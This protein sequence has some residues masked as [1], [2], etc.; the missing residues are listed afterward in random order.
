MKKIIYSALVLAAATG[1]KK[2]FFNRAPEDQATVGT[3]YQTTDEVQSS[4]N[5]LYAAPWFGFNGKAFLAVG[6]LQAGN[7][8]CYAGTDGE[9]DA[10]RNFSQG[11]ATL[12]V[13]STWNSLYTV[14]AQAN[15]LLN[16]LPSAVPGSVPASV[17][18][19][20]L[21][22]ARTM[23]AAAY[24]Y[25]VR[26][27]GNVPIITDPAKYTGTFQTVPTNPVTDIYKFITLDLQ[28]AEANCTHGDATSG[29]VSS[30][31]ASGLLAKVYLYEQKYDS[32]QI[33]A[34]KVINSGYF[35]L[36][37]L[38]VAGSYTGIFEL[39]GNNC[40][41]SMI[42]LQWTSNGGY[43]FG[44]QIQSVI[45]DGENGNFLTGTGDG[46]GELGPSWDLQDAFK[47]E[48][49]SIRRHGCI[50]LP[51]EYY[52]E[53]HKAQGG[54]TCPLQVNE[55][56]VHAAMKKYVVGTPA[57]N[58]G[59]SAA[60]ATSNNTYILRYA[61]IYLIE[62]EA[63]MGKAAGVTPGTGM[64]LSTTSSDPTAL[65]YIN[66]IRQRAG[67]GGWTSFS[68]QQLL[69]ERRL[70]FAIEAD[71]WYD[72]Q[73]IDGFNNAHHP[74]AISIISQQNRGDSNSAG[75]A[76]NNYTDYQR[77]TVYVTP[78]DANFLMPIPATETA[79]DP[80]LL[81]PPVPYVF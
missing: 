49:D 75:T 48:G 31:S 56:G 76:A 80:T 67:L 10:F 53:L 77:N 1:C 81:Q 78:T 30:E 65:K 39:A 72:L 79:A 29:H 18:N 14:V 51:G 22:E 52:A 15:A 13:Q 38:D 4:P 63:I 43:G 12:A 3:Y 11:N 70:E 44:N 27:F 61:D 28:F 62:A 57:D 23:R 60:Q 66:L 19:Q 25:L 69:N 33:E 26:L 37:G 34:E 9:F 2:N 21:G 42:A 32:A 36:M 24:F 46:Y 73:R 6:D 35:G 71:Y 5:I 68:Y 58:N 7:A 8:V 64:P 59:Q 45:A 54:Y 50:M 47:N 74:V 20:A 17:V 41:E 40:K 55:Q 16:N